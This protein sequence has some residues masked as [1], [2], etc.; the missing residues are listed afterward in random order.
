MAECACVPECD[1]A[2][3]WR[4]VAPVVFI[5]LK[6][7]QSIGGDKSPSPIPG[8]QSAFRRRA[9]RSV[10]CRRDVRQQSIL[11]APRWSLLKR[12]PQLQPALLSLSAISSQDR[13]T[14]VFP[15]R[16]FEKRDRRAT[17]PRSDRA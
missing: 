14:V 12:S 6:F 9:Q 10:D 2:G 4:R 16:A 13:F 11:F 8:T 1:T 17:G 15:R 3:S 7:G 5:S